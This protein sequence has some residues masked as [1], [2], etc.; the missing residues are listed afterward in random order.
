MDYVYGHYVG[1]RKDDS[2]PVVDDKQ[3]LAAPP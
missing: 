3:I 1:G 2:W